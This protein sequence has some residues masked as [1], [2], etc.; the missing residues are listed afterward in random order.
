M[1]LICQMTSNDHMIEGSHD[2]MV[3]SSSLYVT[4]QPSLENIGIE[5]VNMFLISHMI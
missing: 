1:Y 4:T 5:V 3:G 2:I